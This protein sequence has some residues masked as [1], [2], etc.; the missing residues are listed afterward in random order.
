MRSEKTIWW[1]WASLL[2][3]IGILWAFLGFSVVRQH[4]PGLPGEVR[5][6]IGSYCVI[7]IIACLAAR[8]QIYELRVDD[9]L[10]KRNDARIRKW[11]HAAECSCSVRL[12]RA[13]AF[14]GGLQTDVRLIRFFLRRRFG[15][16]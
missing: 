15:F 4:G 6:W 9:E 3:L 7:A 1:F 12:R 13:A 14:L 5:F 8:F 2:A 11:S 10:R 16:S